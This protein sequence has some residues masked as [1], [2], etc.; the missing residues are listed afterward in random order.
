MKH[1]AWMLTTAWMLGTVL[2]TAP[3]N[4]ATRV[5]STSAAAAARREA[6]AVKRAA[7]MERRRVVEVNK[8][9]LAGAVFVSAQDVLADRL[10]AS[11]TTLAT[12]ERSVLRAEAKTDLAELAA[13]RAAV[14]AADKAAVPIVV[15][16]IGDVC[17]VRR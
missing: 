10:A 14:R 13:V 5:R 11:D 12:A 1:E 6:T 15:T 16:C 7:A 9:Q 2:V 17:S 3:L 4:A 8:L